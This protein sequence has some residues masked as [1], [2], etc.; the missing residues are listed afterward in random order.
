VKWSRWVDQNVNDLIAAPITLVPLAV[1]QQRNIP[2]KESAMNIGSAITLRSERTGPRRRRYWLAAFA[3]PAA[4]TTMITVLGSA[5]TASAAPQASAVTASAAPRSSPVPLTPHVKIRLTRSRTYC[6]AIKNG[7]HHAGAV[8]WLYKCTKSSSDTWLEV[9][10]V[11]GTTGQ[12]VC[13]EFIDPKKTSLC[14]SLNPARKVVLHGCGQNGSD[15]P[16]LS[17]WIVNTGTEDGWRNLAWGPQG[18]M[19]VAK[20]RDKKPLIGLDAGAG[21]NGCWFH[22]TDS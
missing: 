5:A 20:N 1:R 13:T 8:V 16:N 14:L 2:R 17:L 19:A 18:D 11:C 12:S 3:A 9:G 4:I 15:P 10:A 6:A 21:C 7:N 22:W